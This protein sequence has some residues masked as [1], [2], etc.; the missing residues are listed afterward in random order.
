MTLK[1]INMLLAIKHAKFKLVRN[2]I[3]DD[4]Q[5]Q[6]NGY[7]LLLPLSEASKSIRLRTNVSFGQVCHKSQRNS[8]KLETVTM[9]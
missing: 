5:K 6:Q 2:A 8:S 9:Q 4:L 1:S 3:F 7:F